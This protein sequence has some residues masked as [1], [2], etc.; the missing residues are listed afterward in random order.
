MLACLAYAFSAAA[1]YRS[2]P[3]DQY[4]QRFLLLAVCVATFLSFATTHNMRSWLP[5]TITAAL[6]LSLFTHSIFPSLRAEAFEEGEEAGYKNDES[7]CQEKQTETT[8]S[9]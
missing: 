7:L 2:C 9:F 5:P 4:Q 6:V 8:S 3:N 1:F